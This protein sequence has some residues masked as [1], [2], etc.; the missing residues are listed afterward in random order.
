M[1]HTSSIVIAGRELMHVAV[2]GTP[3]KPVEAQSREAIT[4]AVEDIGRAG[5]PERH[6]VRSRLFARDAAARQA[7][8]NARLD[9]L[10]G[11]RRA[12]SSS[13]IDPQRLAAGSDMMIELYA[14][15]ARAGAGPKV[16]AEY[17]P[18]IAP[19]QFVVLDGLLVLSGDTDRSPGL[20]QQMASIRAKL[21]RSLAEGGGRWE[22][23]HSV[24]VFLARRLPAGAGRAAFAAHFPSLGCPVAFSVVDGYSNA[25]KLVEVEVTADLAS[26]AGRPV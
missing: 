11:E 8:S 10:A 24:S 3:G 23:V 4:R 26:P 13:F 6:I 1:L 2:A 21:D 17:R 14:L 16:I 19:P 15:V 12:A 22:Q 25:E 20:E 5:L 9:V 18:P 7:A